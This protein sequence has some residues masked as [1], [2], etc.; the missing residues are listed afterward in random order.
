MPRAK[1]ST[2]KRPSGAYRAR[3]AHRKLLQAWTTPEIASRIRDAA[4]A[5]GRPL[6]QF[7]IHYGL[8]AGETILRKK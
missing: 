5:D 7:L 1:P 4:I 3:A 8:M 2:A 6:S